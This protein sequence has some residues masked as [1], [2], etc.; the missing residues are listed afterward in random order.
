MS[1]IIAII[2]FLVAGGVLFV[3]LGIAVLRGLDFL[4]EN[5]D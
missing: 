1:N 2:A 5:D 3:A 4:E